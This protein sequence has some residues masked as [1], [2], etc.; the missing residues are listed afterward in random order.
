MVV[1]SDCD[2]EPED[3]VVDMVRS[4]NPITQPLTTQSHTITPVLICYEFDV[5]I[6]S[7][8]YVIETE[9]TA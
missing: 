6:K 7:G 4:A 1:Y 8:K 3:F 9:V 5:M 2:L